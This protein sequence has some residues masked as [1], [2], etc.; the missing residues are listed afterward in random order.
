MKRANNTPMDLLA[1]VPTQVEHTNMEALQ[2][3]P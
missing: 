2:N 3:A 1:G